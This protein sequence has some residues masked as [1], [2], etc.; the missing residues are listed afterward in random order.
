MS[1]IIILIYHY[2]PLTHYQILSYLT[3]ATLCLLL[4]T[5][6]FITFSPL[7][8]PPRSSHLP[9]HA[10][11][12]SFS[13]KKGEQMI[14]KQPNNET[15]NVKRS[16]FQLFMASDVLSC[17]EDTILQSLSEDSYIRLLSASTCWLHNSFWV[18]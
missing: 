6:N 7:A 1:L 3:L 14:N 15:R 11:S 18:W 17:T 10:Y 9:T 4:R 5:M 13:L 12:Y 8:T 2:S 16:S